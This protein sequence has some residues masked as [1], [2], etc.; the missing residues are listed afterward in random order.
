M[1][2]P[3]AGLKVKVI[4]TRRAMD[5][6]ADIPGVAPRRRPAADPSQ[7]KKILYGVKTTLAP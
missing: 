3:V 1:I 6:V 5:I 2:R 7:Q 4:G